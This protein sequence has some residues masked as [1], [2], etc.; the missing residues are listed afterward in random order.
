MCVET[1]LQHVLDISIGYSA[2]DSSAVTTTFSSGQLLDFRVRPIPTDQPQVLVNFGVVDIVSY[3]NAVGKQ[4]QLFVHTPAISSRQ[5]LIQAIC[6]HSQYAMEEIL[7]TQRPLSLS[8]ALSRAFIEGMISTGNRGVVEPVKMFTDAS[9]Q[10][11]EPPTISFCAVD[12]TGHLLACGGRQ[13]DSVASVTDAEIRAGL[14]SFQAAESMYFEDVEWVCDNLGAQEAVTGLLPDK[15]IA[16]TT[17]QR[18]DEFEPTFDTFSVTDIRGQN[19]I[20]ADALAA[21][22]RHRTLDDSFVYVSDALSFR[23][24]PPV[25]TD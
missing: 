4:R 3:L 22:S 18:L 10:T 24:R 23:N 15:P 14:C 21:D 13:L 16:E 19:N 6:S 1:P 9:V 12:N 17:V 7:V 2:S 8:G 5:A 11:D 20:V 25:W